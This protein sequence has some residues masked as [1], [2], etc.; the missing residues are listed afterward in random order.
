MKLREI[1]TILCCIGLL[2]CN[3]RRIEPDKT[4]IKFYGGPYDQQSSGLFSLADKGFLLYGSTYSTSG[5]EQTDAYL[6]KTD[7]GGLEDWALTLGDDGND[8]MNG[9]AFA[10]NQD[11]YVLL[12]TR[13]DQAGDES[14]YLSRTNL[15]GTLLWDSA[16]SLLTNWVI[17]SGIIRTSDDGYLIVGTRG[18][19]NASSDSS[20]VFLLKVNRLGTQE[21]RK[22]MFTGPNTQG[23]KVIEN[24]MGYFVLA[25][26]ESSPSQPSLTIIGLDKSGNLT[27]MNRLDSQPYQGADMVLLPNG[28]LIVLC[29]LITEDDFYGNMELIQLNVDLSI[30]DQTTA[31]SSTRI[32][33]N[34]LHLGVGG[35]LFVGGT[36]RDEQGN[37]A[38]LLLKMGP[39]RETVWD[40]PVRF[41]YADDKEV[42]TNE[43]AGIHENSDGTLFVS[44]TITFGSNTM[45][46]LIK[47]NSLGELKP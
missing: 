21:W 29:T 19:K 37:T 20:S 34:Q 46:G 28:G 14:I 3:I 11:G 1:I 9:L 12:S 16:Y 8:V 26:T 36:E 30:S 27:G 24:Q 38:M 18:K 5:G 41:G 15:G 44:G 7:E 6:V 45:I 43:L 13:E 31:I 39:D 33:A 2:S 22:F 47:T 25:Q 23:L 40:S 10:P 35:D 32:H 4:F 17:G 42:G